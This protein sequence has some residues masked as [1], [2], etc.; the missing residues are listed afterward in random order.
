MTDWCTNASEANIWT[1]TIVLTDVLNLSASTCQGSPTRVVYYG[2]NERCI[3]NMVAQ[4]LTHV[5]NLG[6]PTYPCSPPRVLYHGTREK[7]IPNVVARRRS[8]DAPW[9]NAKGML[10]RPS[11]EWMDSSSILRPYTASKSLQQKFDGI[12][13]SDPSLRI[14]NVQENPSA[15]M[16]TPAQVPDSKRI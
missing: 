6:V 8:S 13:R 7:C 10:A 12:T 4:S 1:S 5:L 9:T 3:S 2:T 11:A 16:K 15:D 14:D